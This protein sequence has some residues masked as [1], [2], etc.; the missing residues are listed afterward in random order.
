MPL[1]SFLQAALNMV[2]RGLARDLKSEGILVMALEPGWVRTRLG[3]P[4]AP[5]SP[6]ESVQEILHLVTRLDK[7]H[8]GLHV[9]LYGEVV[10]W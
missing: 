2:I 10:P 1:S 5:L 8:H 7:S 4:N 3:G 6:Q 9:D